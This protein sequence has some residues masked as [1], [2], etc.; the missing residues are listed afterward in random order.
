MHHDGPMERACGVG[1]RKTLEL[2]SNLQPALDYPDALEPPCPLP[3]P[4]TMLPLLLLAASGP[5]S[6]LSNAAML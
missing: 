6:C 3:P 4:L 5:D 1:G 2:K